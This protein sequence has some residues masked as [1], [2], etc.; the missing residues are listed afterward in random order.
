MTFHISQRGKECL[1]TAQTLLRAA[2]T[3]TD[4][5]M[6]VSL[7]PLPTTTSGELRKLR[8]LMLHPE[9]GGATRGRRKARPSRGD[10]RG[11][12]VRRPRA[13]RPPVV[14]VAQGQELE[15]DATL[16]DTWRFHL[17]DL[18]RFVGDISPIDGIS[19]V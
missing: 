12:S 6:R 18:L 8:M 4:R 3:M 9:R 2:Q 1:K 10:H 15:A 17:A 14:S 5:A 16:Q 11:G 19:T 7:R 13:R